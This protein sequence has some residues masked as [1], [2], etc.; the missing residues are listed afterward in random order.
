MTSRRVGTSI[1]RP[2][3]DGLDS[4]KSAR[5]TARRPA[6]IAEGGRPGCRS[7]IEDPLVRRGS[8]PRGSEASK[9]ERLPGG[10]PPDY[11]CAT[12]PDSRTPLTE[13]LSDLRGPRLRDPRSL[14]S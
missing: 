9:A 5:R 4:E 11:A 13:P 10:R 7:E 6:T 1:E 2:T 12:D 3:D 14:A 8:V